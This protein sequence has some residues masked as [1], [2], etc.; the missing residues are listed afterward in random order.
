[1]FSLMKKCVLHHP[2]VS[3]YLDI[4]YKEVVQLLIELCSL[5][6]FMLGGMLTINKTN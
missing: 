6:V 3:R 2:V 5:E 1:M 4:G